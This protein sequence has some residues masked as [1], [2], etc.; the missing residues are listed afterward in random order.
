MQP[1]ELSSDGL[2][3]SLLFAMGRSSTAVEALGLGGEGTGALLERTGLPW[4][5]RPKS[6][7]TRRP[8]EAGR[9]GTK[10][11]ARE[12]QQHAHIMG[13]DAG[14]TRGLP[15]RRRADALELL[16]RLRAQRLDAAVVERLGDEDV[17]QTL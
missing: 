10:L 13:R 8:P 4:W 7:S 2:G 5:A 12:Y 17:L 16:P 11:A 6:R 1:A 9:Q 15:Y 3:E 14:D